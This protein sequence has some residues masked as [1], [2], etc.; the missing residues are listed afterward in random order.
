ME[1][2]FRQLFE[3]ESSTY[4]YLLADPQ[5]REAVIIDP[6]REMADRDLNLIRELELKLKFILDTHI[7]ADHVTGAGI[8]RE[9]TGA[10]TGVSSG[11]QVDCAD[12]TLKDGD[13]LLF[14]N[15]KI[16]AMTTPGH[17]DSCMSYY[18]SGRVFTG[19]SLMIRGTGRTDFQQG[20]SERLYDS[21]TNKLFKL[22]PETLVFP[23][24]DYRG[25]TC[26]SIA[27]EIHF[28]PRLAG[29][30]REDFVKIMAELK[31]SQPKKIHEALPANLACG[32]KKETL[33]LNPQMVGGVPE[34]SPEALKD[35]LGKV[36]V[37]DVRRPDEFIGE[38]GHVPGSQLIT[39]GPDLERFLESADRRQA[40]VF[41]C[42]SGARSA[43]A[44]IY[45]RSLG[46]DNTANVSGGM[47]R[48][49]ELEFPVER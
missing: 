1:P 15:F 2:I 18:C 3:C 29:K 28:N 47:V 25:N 22:P 32:M 34:I 13:E 31:L 33:M 7:H 8:L 11:A 41:V 19:D 40:L 24:H 16:K 21:I 6:V 14:G 49:N 30:R 45:S 48:W 43:R 27:E 46:F 17:T 23:A 36:R 38:L 10:K 44:A 26:S 37:I 9:R 12:L 5:T 4:T 39:L 20:S 35:I 42:Q